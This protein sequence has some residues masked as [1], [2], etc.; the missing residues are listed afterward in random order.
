MQLQA[1]QRKAY[2]D[3]LRKALEKIEPGQINLELNK[4]CSNGCWF[5]CVS[6]KKGA[7][8]P[9]PFDL[10]EDT[11]EV[12]STTSGIPRLIIP[13]FRSDP[14]DYRTDGKTAIDVYQTFEKA[15]MPSI[16]CFIRTAAPN[17]SEELL[18]AML[19]QDINFGLTF[20]QVNEERLLRIPGI[21]GEL[22]KYNIT[23]VT[24]P[25]SFAAVDPNA[26]RLMKQTRGR[27]FE[28]IGDET[29]TSDEL[30][31]DFKF[32]ALV[33]IFMEQ[34]TR[35]QGV[36]TKAIEG[37]S[38]VPIIGN[39]NGAFIYEQPIS[40]K[41]E[42]PLVKDIAQFS[43]LVNS[44]R[45]KPGEPFLIRFW[46]FPKMSLRQVL[47]IKF[48]PAFRDWSILNSGRTFQRN[49]EFEYNAGCG[50]TVRTV[51]ITSDGAM[52]SVRSVRPSE[53]NREGLMIEQISGPV[54]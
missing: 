35:K 52:H 7:D 36:F 22:E 9:I 18:L 8:R 53:G 21:A 41:R 20:S 46:R 29:I 4:G 54:Y 3:N 1:Y 34:F 19:N 2:K 51:L 47:D 27:A 30:G 43:A 24:V 16:D 44:G 15:Y 49:F 50:P 37:N 38:V 12:I 26:I 48:T 45:L 13:H 39:F 31:L 33:K 28:T 10:I 25:V 23:Q 11:K 40:E 32:H 5:C 6:A 14:L 42:L 17:D